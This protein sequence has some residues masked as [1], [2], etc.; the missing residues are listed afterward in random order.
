VSTSAIYRNAEPFNWAQQLIKRYL[1]TYTLEIVQVWFSA[2]HFEIKRSN[3]G[4][5]PSPTLTPDP[6]LLQPFSIFNF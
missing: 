4:L 1:V 2:P 3:G 6:A 5:T